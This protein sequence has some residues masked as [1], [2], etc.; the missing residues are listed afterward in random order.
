[1]RSPLPTPSFAAALRRELCARNEAFAREHNL[2]HV[3][4]YG[5]LPVVVYSPESDGRRHGNFIL[6]SYG[7]I[8]KRPQWLRRLDKIH[9]QGRKALP[10]ADRA[11]RELDSCTSSD[12]LLMNIFCHRGLCGGRNIALL[13][14]TETS[15]E[16]E[17]GFKARVPLLNGK[18]DRTEVDMKLGRLLV[19]AKLT[20]NDFQIKPGALVESYRDLKKVFDVRALP[21]IGDRYISYQLIRNVLAA[22]AM[23]ASF[24]VIADAR[25]PDLIESWHVIM[26]CVRD[27]GMRTRCKVLAWQE[28]AAALP[29]RLQKFL[30]AKYGINGNKH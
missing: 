5:A 15:D 9:A 3:L 4:S 10:R 25:R 26:R 7:E 24:C 11:W 27:A 1:M 13:L 18:T 20:E 8:L 2:G 6:S 23:E 28:L 17:F 29:A 19:E 21:R 12:A 30:A 16:P 14:G 22:Y